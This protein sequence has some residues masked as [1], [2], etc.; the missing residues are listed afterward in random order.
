M[1]KQ[2]GLQREKIAKLKALLADARV[3]IKSGAP[4]P[5]SEANGGGNNGGGPSGPQTSDTALVDAAV[6]QGS[7]RV[8]ALVREVR[9]LERALES[10]RNAPIPPPSS[11]VATASVPPPQTP[12]VAPPAALPSPMAAATAASVLGSSGTAATLSSW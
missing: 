11:A 8:A 6:A 10:A 12:P 1:Q 4:P 7:A 5:A 3:L 9:L 2:D